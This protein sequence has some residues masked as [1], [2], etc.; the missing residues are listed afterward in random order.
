M[1]TQGY[2]EEF[3]DYARKRGEAELRDLLRAYLQDQVLKG[4]KSIVKTAASTVGKLIGGATAG[5]TFSDDIEAFLGE[6]H[7]VAGDQRAG[8]D[9][10]STGQWPMRGSNPANTGAVPNNRG[11]GPTRNVTI[12]WRFETGGPVF[13]S[14]AV[15]D[16]TVYV[17]SIDHHMNAL[18]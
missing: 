14:P 3:L 7:D 17:G 5:A 13:S 8:T 2:R 10:A 11:R 9:T 12:K 16:G 6:L 4:G 15:V 1:E 18:E